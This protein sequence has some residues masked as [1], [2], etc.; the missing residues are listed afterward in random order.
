VSG[1]TPA[2]DG[3]AGL[4]EFDLDSGSLRRVVRLPVDGLARVLGD[5]TLAPDGTIYLPDSVGG[6][7]WRLAP[8]GKELERFLESDEFVSLQGVVVAPDGKS[9]FLT[10]HANGVLRVDLAKHTVRRLDTPPNTTLIGLDGLALAPNGDLLAVQNGLH[11][12]RVLRL[13]V[14]DAGASVTDVKVLESAHLA[15]AE[16]ALGCVADGY[17]VFIGNAGWSR[18]ETPDPKPTAP[19]PVPIFRTKL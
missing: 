15:M 14:D 17:F 13:A 6:T 19:R 5:L 3:T 12:V 10:D 8:K 16:P 9:L 7:L 4:A 11:P 18:F 2:Q 1:Y